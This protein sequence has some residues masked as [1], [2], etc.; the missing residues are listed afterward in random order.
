MEESVLVEP[1]PVAEDA[2]KVEELT[3]DIYSLSLLVDA[4]SAGDLASYRKRVVFL[5]LAVFSLQAAMA[6][7]YT[8]SAA[9]G[10]EEG[11][12]AQTAECQKAGHYCGWAG[13]FF[14]IVGVQ[15]STDVI[16]KLGHNRR[17]W[18]G[19]LPLFLQPLGGLCALGSSYI[20]LEQSISFAELVM[21]FAALSIIA[22]ADDICLKACR[23]GFF[24]FSFS[25][26]IPSKFEVRLPARAAMRIQSWNGFLV[27]CLW[28]LLLAGA[29]R[30][31]STC[32]GQGLAD[33]FPV[34]RQLGP[35]AGLALE[36]LRSRFYG[37]V[38]AP[39]HFGV[40]R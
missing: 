7:E 19:V 10:A 9:G 30:L 34:F 28:V 36:A 27:P 2:V 12:R 20:T 29:V 24:G 18:A 35:R 32:C 4:A 3:E 13:F 14:V 16:P 40:R 26:T 6:V 22:E 17:S 1:G 33:K 15:I 25:K 38:V 31:S 11:A 8:L 37:I 23:R 5:A 39:G 21:N